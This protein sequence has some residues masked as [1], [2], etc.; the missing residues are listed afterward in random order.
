MAA[1]G[2]TTPR[3]AFEIDLDAA[4]DE[5]APVSDA[6]S[7]AAPPAPSTDAA[8]YDAMAVVP[9]PAVAVA[10]APPATPTTPATPGSASSAIDGILDAVDAGA[11]RIV[12]PVTSRGLGAVALA[13]VRFRRRRGQSVGVQLLERKPEP[14]VEPP[15]SDSEAAENA[16]LE[17]GVAVVE[18]TKTPPSS[19]ERQAVR[20]IADVTVHPIDT[21]KPETAAAL[22]VSQEFI[23][24][25]PSVA[26][27]GMVDDFV[28]TTLR[29]LLSVDEGTQT[30][31]V[32]SWFGRQ[33]QAIM[34][35]IAPA[36]FDSNRYGA[37][38]NLMN[39]I[40]G[41][42]IL[43]LAS[44]FSDTGYILGTILMMAQ[45]LLQLYTAGL[46]TRVARAEN[47]DSYGKCAEV[48]L[49]MRGAIATQ[50]IVSINSLGALIAYVVLVRDFV[51]SIAAIYYDQAD[52]FP[53]RLVTNILLGVVVFPLVLKRE[54]NAL[55]L[56]SFISILFVVL[57]VIGTVER[58]S[59][60][61]SNSGTGSGVRPFPDNL[62]NFFAALPVVTFAFN[63]HTS[64]LPVYTS[65]REPTP[66]RFDFVSHRAF[67]YILVLY[68]TAGL[69][70]Y[71]AFG[72]SIDGNMLNSISADND[73][74][75]IIFMLA[76]FCFTILFTFPLVA[77]VLRIGLHF[78]LGAW[79]T[80]KDIDLL[81]GWLESTLI[82]GA[83]VLLGNLIDDVD[84]VFGITGS[85]SSTLLSLIFPAIFY[86]RST[87]IERPHR[88]VV[89]S[90]IVIAAGIIVGVAGLV[91]NI[92]AL[93]A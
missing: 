32:I 58:T 20:T 41:A 47:A 77:F 52:D 13:T 53:H 74:N 34:G 43:G 39:S 4:Y 29:G 76:M 64:V 91:S 11:P 7:L 69:F 63:C 79:R 6:A 25:P 93:V 67:G 87:Q 23:E 42:G 38:F 28:Q 73:S 48:I 86:L 55:R 33:R 21:S 85:V 78:L 54:L 24:L 88:H 62:G 19:P 17:A 27:T 15:I 10:E 83:A 18:K 9:A 46:L 45:C 5:V 3:S 72:D 36:G 66:N 30:E 81:P 57:V 89:Y 12:F 14:T 71:L 1:E 80:R 70:G 2:D 37:L 44:Y 22:A 40:V 65:M 82:F 59:E 51:R 35:M 31:P 50:F 68:M 16:D 8:G 90:Y 92:A 49:G 84:V 56:F 60:M 61:L 26:K 75:L